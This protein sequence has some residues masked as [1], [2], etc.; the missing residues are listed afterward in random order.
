L[1][2]NKL[3]TPYQF[4]FRKNYSTT[5]AIL[6][7][8]CNILDSFVQN[9]FYHTCFLDLTKAFDCVSHESLIKKLLFYNLHP[10]STQ[11]ILSFLS[12]RTQLVRINGSFSDVKKIIHGVRQGSILGSILFLIFSNDL[13]GY[14]SKKNVTMYADDTPNL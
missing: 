8:T 4:G 12:D 3:L 1:D 2:N 10:T 9:E 11:F 5:S 13:P 14:L 7:L 6:H